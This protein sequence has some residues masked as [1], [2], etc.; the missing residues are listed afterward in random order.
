MKKSFGTVQKNCLPSTEIS[1]NSS[2]ASGIIHPHK[3]SQNKARK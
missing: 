3:E 2:D 1:E